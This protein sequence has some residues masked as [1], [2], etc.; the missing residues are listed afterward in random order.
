MC[1]GRSAFTWI[2]SAEVPEDVPETGLYGVPHGGRSLKRWWRQE[3]AEPRRVGMQEVFI[4]EYL[5]RQT[6]EDS[7]SWSV[8]VQWNS[9]PETFGA[10]GWWR[11]SV[12]C[13]SVLVVEYRQ[14][15]SV[16]IAQSVYDKCTYKSLFCVCPIKNIYRRT[17]TCVAASILK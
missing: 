12:K 11:C 7:F 17:C 8:D 3:E 5:H 13:R 9:D 10:I 16:C 1:R 6:P 2:H 4:R 15:A 14:A